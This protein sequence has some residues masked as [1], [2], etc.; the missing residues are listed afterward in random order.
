MNCT[1]TD[2]VHTISVTLGTTCHIRNYLN[3]TWR[4]IICVNGSPEEAHRAEM[5]TLPSLSFCSEYNRS[6]IIFA[7]F[8]C[9]TIG[10]HTALCLSVWGFCHVCERESGMCH[11]YLLCSSVEHNQS[12]WLNNEF[13]RLRTGEPTLLRTQ[14]NKHADEQPQWKQR[15]HNKQCYISGRQRG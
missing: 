5:F 8:R 2:R 10:N 11:V 3:V 1:F 14:I 13:S 15:L 12:V 4:K 7:H 6:A 9:T